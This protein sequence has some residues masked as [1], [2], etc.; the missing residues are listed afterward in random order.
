MTGNSSS[1]AVVCRGRCAIVGPGTVS[2]YGRAIYGERGAVELSDL[3]LVDNKN[4]IDVV[5]A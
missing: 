3:V 5:G 1:G 4:S 2:G